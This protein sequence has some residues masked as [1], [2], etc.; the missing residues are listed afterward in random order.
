MQ[1]TPPFL[2]SSYFYEKLY[3]ILTGGGSLSDLY[4]KLLAFLAAIFPFSLLLSLLFLIGII[5]CSIR[6]G[7][8]RKEEEEAHEEGHGAEHETLHEPVKNERWRTIVSH[9][10]SE[11]QSDWRLAILECDVVLEEM[12]SKMG[13]HGET[14]SDKLKTVERGD[15]STIDQAWEGH[16]VRNAIAHEGSSFDLSHKEARRVVGLYEAV[17]REFRYV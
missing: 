10:D 6:L 16:R 14:V 2:N 8:L 11:N 7:Q 1:G 9:I 15:F 4:R 17:F 13:Y 3:Q 5:Y 12:L